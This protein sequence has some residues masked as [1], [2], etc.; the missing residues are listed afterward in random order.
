M[1][2]NKS[3]ETV[4]HSLDLSQSLFSICPF[5]DY[6]KLLNDLAKK[7]PDNAE[8]I[9]KIDEIIKNQTQTEQNTSNI[10]NEN[11][12]K[13]IIS[14]KWNKIKS[15]VSNISSRYSSKLG[16]ISKLQYSQ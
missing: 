15:L 16:K 14:N 8:I 13:G 10:Q 2:Q 3:I 6:E 9:T 7:Y 11:T 5:K 12:S 1:F 4:T